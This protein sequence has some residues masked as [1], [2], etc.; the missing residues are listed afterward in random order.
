MHRNDTA[1]YMEFYHILPKGIC[2]ADVSSTTWNKHL[3]MSD[4]VE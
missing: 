4:R 1:V 2:M 3:G